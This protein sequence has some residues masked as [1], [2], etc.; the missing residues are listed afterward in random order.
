MSPGTEPAARRGRLITFEGG[1]GAGKSTQLRRLARRLES[2]GVKT[3]ATREPGGSEH[4]EALRRVLLSGRARF[5]GPAGEATL[6]AAARI[7][8]I[9]A[10][11]EP[12]LAS[13]LWV[14]CDRFADSTR[15]YQGA[16]GLDPRL[17]DALE[18]VA[19]N[20][21]APD[22]TLVLDAPAELGLARAARRSGAA[23]DRFEAQ[24]RAF[25]EKIRAAFL[26]VAEENPRRCVVIDAT[27]SED[28]VAAAV[29][30]ATRTRLLTSAAQDAHGQDAH[31]R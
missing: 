12:A 20:G 11:I 10:M 24:S 8:H 16:D 15:A 21:L 9:D 28:D 2:E 29:W 31:G 26:R 27:L 30:R 13:G 6:F 22:L 17:I 23:A 5:L 3:V 1:E 18:H 19:L 14:V 7:D 25:H 4:A